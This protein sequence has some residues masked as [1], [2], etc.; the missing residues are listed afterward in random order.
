MKTMKSGIYS[1]LIGSLCLTAFVASAQEEPS[2]E[3]PK[4][5]A[6]T[7]LIK[8]KIVKAKNAVGEAAVGEEGAVGVGSSKQEPKPG[9]YNGEV[10]FQFSYSSGSGSSK[11]SSEDSKE[12]KTSS[13]KMSF[14][15]TYQFILGKFAVGPILQYS[16]DSTKGTTDG[17]S[18][19]TTINTTGFGIAAEY[20]IF[21]IQTE[22]MVPFVA[23]KYLITSGSNS[24]KPSTGEEQKSTDSGNQMGLGGGIKYFLGRHVSVD[25]A[26]WYVS[27]T[28]T[29]KLTDY[30][31]KVSSTD[32][33][34]VASLSTY[35]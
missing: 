4:A 13:S 14:A 6:G 2:P 5:A 31:T 34:L 29:N 22:K 11:P 3:T 32:I 17:E 10:E 19:T 18:T 20:L 30:S 26:L 16:T 1:L 25:P 33:T 28:N 23:F 9:K 24:T 7:K 35:F 15:T 8:K 27:T 12:T 21:D